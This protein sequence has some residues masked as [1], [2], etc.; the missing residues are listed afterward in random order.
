MA[1]VRD[2]E[3]DAPW[4]A[5]VEREPRGTTVAPRGAVIWVAALVVLLIAAIGGGLWWILTQPRENGGSVQ[6]AAVDPTT[7]PLIPAP[8]EPYKVRPSN[9][10]GMSVEGEGSL[11]YSA[12]EGGT[13]AGAIDVGSLAEDPMARPGE[14]SAATDPELPTAIPPAR[15]PTDL[16]PPG[17]TADKPTPK[18]VAPVEPLPAPVVLPKSLKPLPPKPAADTKSETAP[19]AG[20]NASLQLGA[21]SSSAAADAAWK[22]LSGRYVYLAGLRKAVVPVK[23]DTSTLYRLRASGIA[24]AATAADLCARLKVAGEECL[25]AR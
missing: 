16:L 12:G 4:L 5:E 19:P 9:A 22:S 6:T 11:I 18:P 15:G 10:G 7:L 14:P 2:D 17:L 8:T 21:F 24:D 23:R 13:P 3:D 20:G 1:R 25:V